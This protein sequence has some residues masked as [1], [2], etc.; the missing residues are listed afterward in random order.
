MSC[1]TYHPRASVH[2]WHYTGK[3]LFLFRG[4]SKAWFKTDG[5]KN[6][7]THHD[8]DHRLWRTSVG[9]RLSSLYDDVSVQQH[10]SVY[11]KRWRGSGE[12]SGRSE[13]KTS[14]LPKDD[15]PNWFRRQRCPNMLCLM[16]CKKSSTPAPHSLPH[17][18]NS[19]P[20]LERLSFLMVSS[21]AL[22]PLTQI[23]PTRNLESRHV[24]NVGWIQ[25]DKVSTIIA[26][27]DQTSLS[28]LCYLVSVLRET[29]CRL[30]IVF[31]VSN[32]L[33]RIGSV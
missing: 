23:L 11:E 26:W 31:N 14:I 21:A 3:C 2:K 10:R 30:Q 25:L 22:S 17:I 8:I 20:T 5:L 24:E 6:R 18:I 9:L 27:W 13:T 16:W 1:A 15:S 29:L 28:S 19:S 12:A 32:R 4:I 7:H 33:V